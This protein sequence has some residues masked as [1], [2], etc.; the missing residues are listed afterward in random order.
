[1]IVAAKMK[2]QE[3]YSHYLA[4]WVVLRWVI[5]M[6][7]PDHLPR[8]M[9]ARA[10]ELT[11]IKFV[12]CICVCINRRPRHERE[13]EQPMYVAKTTGVLSAE[14]E[15]L[16]GIYYRPRT[17]ETRETYEVLLSFLQHRIGD[18]VRQHCTIY[19]ISILDL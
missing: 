17:K 1:M 10:S 12:I 14:M 13:E 11:V 3:R 19:T 15:D 5:D 16:A 8:K 18:Q 9:K 4:N 6:S 7:E 2:L